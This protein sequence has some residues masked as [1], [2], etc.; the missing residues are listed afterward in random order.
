MESLSLKKL[1]LEKPLGSSEKVSKS[2]TPDP[3]TETVK[4]FNGTF[5]AKYQG[6]WYGSFPTRVGAE[7]WLEAQSDESN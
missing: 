4:L 2:D 7:V 1:S 3:N 6:K 5:W